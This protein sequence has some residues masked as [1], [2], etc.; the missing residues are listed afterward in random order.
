M[1]ASPPQTW[2]ERF[3]RSRTRAL[4]PLATPESLDARIAAFPIEPTDW[5]NPG[6]PMDELHRAALGAYLHRQ[7]AS[8]SCDLERAVSFCAS[9]PEGVMLY[10]LAIVAWDYVDGVLL[11]V[12]GVAGGPCLTQH[13]YV[14]IEPQAQID[15]HRVDFLLTMAVKAPTKRC[16]AR[17]VVECD[18][19]AFHE[20]TP[21]QA[22]KDRLRDRELQAQDLVVYRY[23][24]SEL[25]TDVFS[26]ANSAIE[27]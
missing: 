1:G 15:R 27:S 24:G 23:T 4:G 19:H 16:E 8:V 17:M 10:A 9:P 18:G 22:R 5:S 12:G 21:A 13:P 6:G 11:R 2:T 3:S 14:E 7:V 20:R 26:A 25:W